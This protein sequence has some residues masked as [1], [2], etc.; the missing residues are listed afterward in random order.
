MVFFKYLQ[1]VIKKA[2]KLIKANLVTAGIIDNIS[3]I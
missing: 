1:F 2:K 3:A